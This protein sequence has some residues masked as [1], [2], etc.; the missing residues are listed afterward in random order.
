M[1][2]DGMYKGAVRGSEVSHRIPAYGDEWREAR[3]GKRYEIATARVRTGFRSTAVYLRIA[4]VSP[5]RVHCW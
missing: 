5:T 4:M 1:R 2:G 3:R